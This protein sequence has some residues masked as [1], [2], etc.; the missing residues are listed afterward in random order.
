MKK[1]DNKNGIIFGST[2]LIGSNLAIKLGRL[3]ANLILHGSSITKLKTLDDEFK[4]MRKKPILMVADVTKDHFYENLF[5]TVSLRFKKIDFLINLIGKFPGLKPLTH[6]SHK[7]WESLYKINFLSFWRVIKE[8]E[9]LIRESKKANIIFLNNKQIA[10][11]KAYHH[12]LSIFNNA[13]YSLMKVFEKEN[14]KLNIKLHMIEVAQINQ[15]ITSALAGKKKIS[16]KLIDNS[17][18]EIVEKICNR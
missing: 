5:N 18:K 7:E 1:L 16:Q 4:N 10:K 8:L 6:L 11:G 13:K 9:P 14:E 17:V 15:G 12:T 3:D 2:G